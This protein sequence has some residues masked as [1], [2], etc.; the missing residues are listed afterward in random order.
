MQSM[1]LLLRQLAGQC[2]QATISSLTPCHRGISNGCLP[3]MTVGWP[4]SAG[5]AT[6]NTHCGH[7]ISVPC[8]ARSRELTAALSHN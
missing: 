6:L 1:V 3:P 2:P 7:R 5:A 8:A 4:A